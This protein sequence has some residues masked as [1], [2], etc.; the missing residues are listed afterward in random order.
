M[1]CW[2]LRAMFMF[3]IQFAVPANTSPFLKVSEIEVKLEYVY[4][5]LVYFTRFVL[6]QL[7]LNCYENPK[8]LYAPKSPFCRCAMRSD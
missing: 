2:D 1:Y 5:P 7:K 3:A 8:T 6:N 4:D